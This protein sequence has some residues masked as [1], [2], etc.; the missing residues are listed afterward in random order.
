MAQALGEQAHRQNI[1]VRVIA[2]CITEA[3]LISAAGA[4][5]VV[6]GWATGGHQ[7]IFDVEA[8]DGVL[9][10]VALVRALSEDLYIPIVAALGLMSG[11]NIFEGLVAGAAGYCVFAVTRPARLPHIF[12]C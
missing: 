12:K 7:G 6:R 3:K 8:N 9:P 10:L 2:T 11:G 1:A 4:D 5:F